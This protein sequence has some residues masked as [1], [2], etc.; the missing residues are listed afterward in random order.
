MK[1]TNENYIKIVLSILLILCLLH[2]PYSYYRLV[3]FIAV[4][5]FAILAYYEYERKNIP[6]AIVFILL[7][8]LFQPL[9]GI[10]L[11][12]LVWNVVDVLVAIGLIVTIF[13]QKRIDR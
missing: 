12:R 7:A 1:L 6:M 9:E 3:R 5:G 13:I 2:L 10:P 8:V 4:I 11:G